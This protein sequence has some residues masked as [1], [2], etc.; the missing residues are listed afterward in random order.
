[1]VLVS[2]LSQQSI[3]RW[4]IRLWIISPDRQNRLMYL[5]YMQQQKQR[6]Y[7]ISLLLHVTN[8]EPVMSTLIGWRKKHVNMSSSH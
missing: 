8:T 3:T 6:Q 2:N 4:T 1:M 7:C 5:C